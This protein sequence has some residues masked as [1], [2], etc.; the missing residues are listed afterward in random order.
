MSLPKP[1]KLPEG[2]CISDKLRWK[3]RDETRPTGTG[4]IDR[5]E[6]IEDDIRMQASRISR[7]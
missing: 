7:N 1:V 2:D 5:G 6:W 4:Q 3:G